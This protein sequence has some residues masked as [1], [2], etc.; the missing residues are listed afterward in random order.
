MDFNDGWIS[1]MEISG[2]NERDEF[3]GMDFHDEFDF[4]DVFEGMDFHNGWKGWIFMMDLIS[5]MNLKG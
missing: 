1:G 5:T 3:Q 2:M 4:N